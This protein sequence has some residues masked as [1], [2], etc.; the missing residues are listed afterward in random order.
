MKALIR[1]CASLLLVAALLVA[2]P[3]HAQADPGDP[4]SWN[5]TSKALGLEQVAV[6]RAP[7]LDS[8]REGDGSPIKSV[9]AGG[10]WV[11]VVFIHG[12]TDRATHTDQ[13]DVQGAFSRPINLTA[14]RLGRADVRRSMIGQAQGIPGA[15][16]FTYD[17]HPYSGCWVTDGHIGPGLG[18]VID[19][20]FAASGQKVIF[21][22]HSMGGLAARYAAAV[23]DR[24]A[25]ISRTITFGTPNLGSHLAG[26]A[27]IVLSAMPRVRF[28]L[29][30][31]IHRW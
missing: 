2:R 1:L 30:A 9:S 11:P 18:K 6:Q 27:G 7:I 13:A 15:A 3:V 29:S 25:K 14:N 16:V 8:E 4:D 21:V 10:L 23:P 26:T 20:L 31:L 22:G 5:C 24:T 17:Y 12:W 19:C 28:F